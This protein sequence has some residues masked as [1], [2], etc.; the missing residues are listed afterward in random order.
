M[1]TCWFL[2]YRCIPR[3][4]TPILT[5]ITFVSNFIT[6]ATDSISGHPPIRHRSS[7][8][9]ILRSRAG[10]SANAITYHFG[11]KERLYRDI[12]DSFASLQLEHAKTVLSADPRSRQEFVIRV[13][14]FF[15]QLLDAYLTNRETLRIMFREFEQLLPHGDD[16]VIGEMV[17]T[18]YAISE[19][20]KRA[21]DLGFVQADVDPD[22]V[23]GLL[24]DRLLN[25]ARFVHAHEM[26]FN[27]S[28]LDPEYRAHWVRATLRIVFD[29]INARVDPAA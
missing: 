25:Q 5:N 29:G 20:I 17:K 12:L 3:P 18:S 11:S 27:V 10:V 16:G 19:F 8:C 23:A 7:H 22:I 28:T 15:E 9:G 24:M 1:H 4:A 26:F 21:M 13:E 6:Y 14:L 2:R